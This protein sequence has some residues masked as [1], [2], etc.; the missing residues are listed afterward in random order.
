MKYIIIISLMLLSSTLKANDSTARAELKKANDNLIAGTAISVLSSFVL[1]NGIVTG[2]NATTTVGTIGTL[3]GSF[4]FI[5]ATVHYNQSVIE[6]R[7]GVQ[8]MS[9]RLK[10]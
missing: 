4:C 10:F 7:L 1:Y 6:T 5:K 3:V 2:N 8:S 9:I